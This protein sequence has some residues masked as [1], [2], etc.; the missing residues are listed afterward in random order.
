M[1]GSDCGCSCMPASEGEQRSCGASHSWAGSWEA[2][3]TRSP[4]A[5]PG[6]V[7]K[8]SSRDRRAE[9]R[10]RRAEDGGQRRGKVRPLGSRPSQRKAKRQ[11][12]K[13]L[14]ERERRPEDPRRMRLLP[15]LFLAGSLALNLEAAE[16]PNTK[17]ANLVSLPGL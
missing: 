3:L 15:V 5:W 16:K 1:N 10:G 13:L 9:N 6:A 11:R 12:R 2:R 17:K 7:P 14:R 8:R 4:V